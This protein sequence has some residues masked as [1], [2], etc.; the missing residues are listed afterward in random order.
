MEGKR[1]ITPDPML[2]ISKLQEKNAYKTL[3]LT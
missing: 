3:T 1:I 2:L